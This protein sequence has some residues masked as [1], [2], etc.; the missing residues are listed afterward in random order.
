M[1]VTILVLFLA[2]MIMQTVLSYFQL[3]SIY[4]VIDA[5]KRRYGAGYYLTTGRS[6]GKS[7]LGKGILLI[8]IV[9]EQNRIME[10]WKMEGY[11]VFSRPR[12]DPKFTGWDLGCGQMENVSGKNWKKALQNA[13]ELLESEKNQHGKQNQ[14]SGKTNKD[15]RE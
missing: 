14:D 9:D 6:K 13:R 11:T 8:I 4:A 10:L 1:W 7:F 12:K 3:R 5:L 2:V 15:V